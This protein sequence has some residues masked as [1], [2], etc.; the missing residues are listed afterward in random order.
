MKIKVL[1][2]GI[3]K[4]IFEKPSIEI[5]LNE[6]PTISS[7]RSALE[8]QYPDLQK[9]RSYM[10]ARNNE[11]TNDLDVILH[12]DEIALIPPVSGG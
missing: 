6:S 11:Y 7:L 2:F 3:V 8:K 4:D 9:L 12:H 1:A 5:S 10:V